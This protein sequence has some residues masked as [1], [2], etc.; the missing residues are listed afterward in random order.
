M[1]F[2]ISPYSAQAH[3]LALPSTSRR[4]SSGPPCLS[5]DDRRQSVCVKLPPG[6]RD[7]GVSGGRRVRRRCHSLDAQREWL[8]PHRSAAV[9]Q[10]RPLHPAGHLAHKQG[11]PGP[12]I[13]CRDT[14]SGGLARTLGVAP[15]RAQP[16]QYSRLRA[17]A[18]G[19]RCEVS[20]VRLEVGAM[21]AAE[22]GYHLYRLG[23]ER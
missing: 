16:G 22:G 3:S 11:P 10:C 15:C 4:S 1:L 20:G 9:G 21:A 6:R 14:R 8:A 18:P 12:R 13:S 17:V 23:V 2:A 5:S 19:S 7:A